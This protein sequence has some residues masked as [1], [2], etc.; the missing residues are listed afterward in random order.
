MRTLYFYH[1]LED[2]FEEQLND[3]YEAVS[4][5]GYDYDAG[6]ALRLIDE[7]AFRCGVCDWS[8]E[9]F[10][11]L[12]TSEL[13]DEEIDHHMLSSNQVMYCRNEDVE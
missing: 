9:E 3:C 7:T 6:R 1:E 12:R 2:M 4:I 13:T 10:E 5:C 11:E 8:S